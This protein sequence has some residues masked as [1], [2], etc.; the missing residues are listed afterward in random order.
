[1][2]T[3]DYQSLLKYS[4]SSSILIITHKGQ[5]KELNCPFKIKVIRNVQNLMK[6]EIKDVIQVKLATNNMFVYII[7]DKPYFYHYFSILI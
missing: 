5:L 2:N 4:S 1:M 7:E 3:K 6:G